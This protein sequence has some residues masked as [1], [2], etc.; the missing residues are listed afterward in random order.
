MIPTSFRSF[1]SAVGLC[2]VL[3]S[4]ALSAQETPDSLNL[5]AN[6][7]FDTTRSKRSF[8][9][10]VSSFSAMAL[11]SLAAKPRQ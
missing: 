10:S 8:G 7:G 2:A 9:G 5:V 1:R 6:G 4:A 11:C 3:A